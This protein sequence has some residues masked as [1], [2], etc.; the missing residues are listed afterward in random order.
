MKKILIYGLGKTGKALVKFCK[1]R[2]ISFTTFDDRD[3]GDINFEDK[4][5][6]CSEI[7]VS[8]GI[9]LKNRNLKKAIQ[10][11]IK[12]ISEI[13][14]ASR[15]ISKP[16]I[17]ITGT[18]GKT[19]TTLI[20]Y[21]LLK[22]TGLN[23]FLGGNIGTPL[24]NAANK[25]NKYDYILIEVSSFQLQFIDSSFKPFISAILNVS[26]NHL[27]HHLD[28]D[29][30]ILC[31]KNI[32]KNQSNQDYL[33]VS[34]K[35][36]TIN[37]INPIKINPLKNKKIYSTDNAIFAEKNKLNRK[38]LKLYGP[39][40]IGNILFSLNI[41][42]IIKK[43]EKKQLQVI[44]KFAPP[45]HRLEKL[46]TKMIIFNDSKSTSPQATEVAIKSFAE[47]IVLIMGGKDKGLDYSS[48][49]KSLKRKVKLLILFGEN[50][51]ELAKTFRD[52]KIYLAADLHASVKEGI[53]R[54][55][56]S[57][58]LLFS[59]GT[60]SFDRYKSYSERGEEFKKYVKELS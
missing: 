33:L 32:F 12:V 26:E 27:D 4:L 16:I 10:L 34:Q 55:N 23:V 29:E 30:Y 42:A 18:N 60:S 25:E 46:K 59:P 9:G 11:G 13:E 58:V 50:K 53:K 3:N 38:E 24:I 19:T 35:E 22:S 51:F 54:T 47:K 48:L 5:K 14:F 36:L 40:N 2:N 7:I 56:T 15:F 1:K 41:I 6:N 37:K 52:I 8:P 28:M 20:T 17:A 43:I 21:D 31:K 45:L 44:K 57:E 49:N 39:H